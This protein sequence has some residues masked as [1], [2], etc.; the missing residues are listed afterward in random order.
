V[1]TSLASE[2]WNCKATENNHRRRIHHR[3]RKEPRQNRPLNANGELDAT[4]TRRSA[5]H[6]INDLA[7]QS[8]GK[9]VIGGE[10]L[11]VNGGVAGTSP[12]LARL[13]PDERGIT[14]SSARRT[15]SSSPSK[16]R[17]TIKFSSAASLPR[18]AALPATVLRG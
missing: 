11:A 12:Y 7:I 15:I 1:K 6:N 13:L 3:Q 16:D 2:I 5:R 8:D 4:L 10:F 14:L 17:H 18:Q 9:I